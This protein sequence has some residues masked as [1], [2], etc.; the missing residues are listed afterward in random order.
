[1]EREYWDFQEKA[2]NRRSLSFKRGQEKKVIIG[3]LRVDENRFVIFVSPDE[4]TAFGTIKESWYNHKFDA[5]SP[6]RFTY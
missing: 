2:P 5:L 3:T 4:P 1:M 6:F